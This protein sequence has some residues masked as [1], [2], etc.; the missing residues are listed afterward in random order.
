MESQFIRIDRT[1]QQSTYYSVLDHK[2]NPRLWI[3]VE[4]YLYLYF[5]YNKPKTI[6][7]F[8][9]L[10]FQFVCFLFFFPFFFFFSLNFNHEK[11][12]RGE[13]RQREIMDRPVCFQ[14]I[15]IFLYIF[16][17]FFIEPID[18]SIEFDS[19]SRRIFQYSI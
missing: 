13:G 19:S 18:S 3:T 16:L 15:H 2:N 9:K 6:K 5:I 12:T 8:F 4:I 10:K 7:L 17:S 14:I 1:N 11:N